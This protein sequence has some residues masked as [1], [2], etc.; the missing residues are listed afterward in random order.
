MINKKKVIVVEGRGKGSGEAGE[1][2][3]RKSRSKKEKARQTTKGG[4]EGSRIGKQKKERRQKVSE[5][6]G[7]RKQSRK[8]IAKTKFDDGKGEERHCIVPKKKQGEE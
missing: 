5:Y 3:S 1:F 4:S 8:R 7:E 2:G 6:V